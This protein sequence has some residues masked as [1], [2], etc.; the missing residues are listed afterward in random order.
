MVKILNDFFDVF[1]IFKIYLTELSPVN[2][3]DFTIIFSK[4]E[5][6]FLNYYKNDFYSYIY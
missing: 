3:L 6:E 1:S 2:E 5:N 4:I